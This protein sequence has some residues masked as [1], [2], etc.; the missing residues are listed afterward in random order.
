MRIRQWLH[1]V[2]VLCCLASVSGCVN[3]P[4]VA[5]GVP[6]IT[7]HQVVT[8][9][10]TPSDTVISLDNFSAQMRYLAENGYRT[11]SVSQ[12]ISYMKHGQRLP[13]KPIVITFDDGWT[14][15]LNAVPVLDKYGMQASFWIVTGEL[16]VDDEYL[17]WNQIAALGKNNRFEI[18]SHSVTHPSDP[19]NNLVTWVG[20][21]PANRQTGRAK[22]ELELSRNELQR[23]LNRPV[24]YLAWPSGIYDATLVKMASHAGYTALL[25]VDPGLNFYGGDW[26]HIK[27]AVVNGACGL[28]S[29][30]KAIGEGISDGCKVD[31]QSASPPTN[32]SK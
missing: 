25:T 22:A 24:K 28:D 1:V 29:F 30:R 12:L 20:G 15:A 32:I 10:T 3:R 6:V 8:D 17:G 11:I 7:Y 21:S 5:V 18:G 23:I 14:S 31:A 27:R 13:D 16:D 26:L 9:G 19:D 2:L 4:K